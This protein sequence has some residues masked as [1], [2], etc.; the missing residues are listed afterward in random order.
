MSKTKISFWQF[1]LN[2]SKAKSEL[3]RPPWSSPGNKIADGEA[4]LR[5]P[6]RDDR[7]QS[8]QEEM[9]KKELSVCTPKDFANNPELRRIRDEQKE[10]ETKDMGRT[11][12][13]PSNLVN[14]ENRPK[15]MSPNVRDPK[16]DQRKREDDEKEANERR[17]REES[18]SS[19]FSWDGSLYSNGGYSNDSGSSSSSSDYSSNDSSS[20]YSGGGGDFGGGGAGDDY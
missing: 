18:N 9:I 4:I 3:Q 5:K 6:Y 8:F 13:F 10:R 16:G 12:P 1:L 19:N 15:P 11:I 7:Q 20:D 2:W 14:T 17:R